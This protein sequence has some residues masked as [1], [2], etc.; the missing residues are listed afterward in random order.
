MLRLGKFI[1]K[2]LV[3]FAIFWFFF[4][5]FVISGWNVDI[6]DKDGSREWIG[7]EFKLKQPIFVFR[8][9]DTGRYSASLPG[10]T[11][12]VPASIEDYLVDPEDWQYTDAKGQRG[13]GRADGVI[14]GD[15]VHPV[16]EGT[17]VTIEKIYYH[18]APMV[19]DYLRI[20]VRVDDAAIKKLPVDMLHFF[21]IDY[22]KRHDDGSYYI[23]R[24]QEDILEEVK[25]R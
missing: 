23:L 12:M 10:L 9:D 22:C 11:C 4:Y 17:H 14:R 25:P 24:F 8:Y 3:Y 6:S 2:S 5:H 18:R 15:W 7:R 16:Y 20:Q 1:V 19:S 21:D 13:W